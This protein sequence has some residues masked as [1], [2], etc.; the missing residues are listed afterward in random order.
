MKFKIAASKYEILGNKFN[1]CAALY[2]ES[3]NHT[4]E[5]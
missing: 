1:V 4:G 3:V 5:K 2:A